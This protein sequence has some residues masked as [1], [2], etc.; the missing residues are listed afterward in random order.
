MVSSPAAIFVVL[1][2]FEL[3][4]AYMT[5]IKMVEGQGV[6]ARSMQYLLGALVFLMCASGARIAF[7][8]ASLE[9]EAMALLE[10][11]FYAL[12]FAYVLLTVL[13]WRGLGK[14]PVVVPVSAT[15]KEFYKR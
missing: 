11:Y 6:F 2:V 9:A 1:V 14:E 10:S 5:V 3:V 7:Y 12:A 4:A 13:A 15:I 8:F